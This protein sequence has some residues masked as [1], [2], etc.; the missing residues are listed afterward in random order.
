MNDRNT[1]MNSENPQPV[2]SNSEMTLSEMMTEEERQEG[3]R[4]LLEAWP[5]AFDENGRFI[6]KRGKIDYSYTREMA[7]RDAK[8]HPSPG[9]PETYRRRQEEA[10]R[11]KREA[12]AADSK[13]KASDQS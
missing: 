9:F 6:A 2:R 1:L 8:G 12:E 3:M 10:A 11:L 13:A 4:Q 7:I 5:G